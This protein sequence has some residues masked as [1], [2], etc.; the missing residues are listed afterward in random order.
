MSETR[1]NQ[2]NLQLKC[3]HADFQELYVIVAFARVYFVRYQRV[4]YRNIVAYRSEC[5]NFLEQAA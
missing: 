1:A 5:S 4:L 2:H 3:Y